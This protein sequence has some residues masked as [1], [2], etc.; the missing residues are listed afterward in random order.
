LGS[1]YNG[2]LYRIVFMSDPIRFPRVAGR[3]PLLLWIGFGGLI[4]LLLVTGVGALSLLH[5]L[6][7]RNEDTRQGYLERT[8]LLDQL[9]SDIYL[10]GTAVRDYLLE[11]DPARAQLHRRQFDV[12]QQQARS[13][14]ATAMQSTAFQDELSSYFAAFDP[15]FEWTREQRAV[16]GKEFMR[17]EVTKRRLSMIRIADEAEQANEQQLETGTRQI[18]QLFGGFRSGLLWLLCLTVALGCVLAAISTTRILTLYSELTQARQESQALSARLLDAQEEERRKISRE[19]HD[20]IGQSLSALLLGLG[21][22][23]PLLPADER[24]TQQLQLLR[25][26]A[27]GCVT[28]VRNISLLLRPSMLDD[29]GLVAALQWKA[30]ELERSSTMR[31]NVAADAAADTL[32]EEYATT[33][34]RIVQEALNNCQR[35]AGAGHV[36]VQLQQSGT[37][38]RLSIQDDGRG[39]RPQYRGLGLL[40]MEERVARLR[41]HFRLDSGEGQG[42]LLVIELPLAQNG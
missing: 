39:F 42:T 30:R 15:V 34:Y 20:E 9:R 2:P 26:L 35:H 27:E 28:A 8:R 29:L 37:V 31:V 21:N 24:A 38:L 10:S 11:D 4:G 41:G 18:E 1:T 40:G 5:A 16:K 3:L 14:A 32:P 12:T 23:V 7:V 25:N 33:I 19:L 22:L 17:D 13:L 36:R 6:E